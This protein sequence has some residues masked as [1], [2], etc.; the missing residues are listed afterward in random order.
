MCAVLDVVS[1]RSHRPIAPIN[2]DF[3]ECCN[4]YAMDFALLIAS[5]SAPTPSVSPFKAIAG[6]HLLNMDARAMD[7]FPPPF[8][9]FLCLGLCPS[10]I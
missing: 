8:F 10:A 6:S 9:F 5:L 3:L 1:S 4:E 7:I 2:T